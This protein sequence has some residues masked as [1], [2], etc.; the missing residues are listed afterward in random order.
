[1]KIEVVQA[2][3]TKMEHIGSG[4][5]ACI[6]TTS[7]LTK[8]EAMI[9]GSTSSGGLMV[10]SETHFLPYMNTRPFRVNAGA[11]HS[12]VWCP[13]DRTEYITD[14]RVGSQVLVVDTDGNTRNVS[15]GRMKIEVRPL[16][17]IEA[18]YNGV[19]IN[20]IVQDDWHIRIF[21]GDGNPQ[22]AT[23]FKV[24]D[25][26]LAY[27]CEPGRHVGVKISEKITEN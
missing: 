12:Y 5:R 15:V 3:V 6:D 17:L 10:C 23:Q 13:N 27:F 7:L 1:G 4:E 22:N 20:T 24:G 21:D 25:K 18:E 8:K 26:I 2:T 14:L 9:I 11:V 19:R 16:L